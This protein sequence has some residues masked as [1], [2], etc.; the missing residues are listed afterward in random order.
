MGLSQSLY[1]A[2]SGLIN[3]QTR[4]DAIGNNLANINTVG[5]KRSVLQFAD[6]FSQTLRGGSGPSSN[7]GGI[8]PI[9]IGLGMQVASV[10]QDFAQGAMEATGR[11]S[12]LAVEGNGFFKLVNAGETRYSRDGAFTL[13]QSGELQNSFGWY[14]QGWMAN[15]AGT[16]NNGGATTNLVIPLGELKVARATSTVDYTG[17]LNASG[18]VATANADWTTDTNNV[19]R[20]TELF[21]ADGVTPATAANQLQDL[22]SGGVQ[23]FPGAAFSS[24]TISAVKGGRNISATV[25][26]APNTQLSVLMTRI[27]NALGI[28]GDAFS[29]VTFIDG[30]GAAVPP[31]GGVIRVAGNSGTLNEISNITLTP[32]SGPARSLFTQTADSNG[33][34]TVTT[35]AA[36]DSLGDVHMVTLTMALVSQT[37][38]GSTWR[39]YADCTDD[40]TPAL[41]VGSGTVTFDAYGQYLTKSANTINIDLGSQGVTT[42]LV[43][44]PD[45]TLLTQFASATGSEVE[46]RSQDGSPMG[47]LSAYSIDVDGVISGL[48]SNGLRRDLGQVCLTQFANNNG[49]VRDADNLFMI[50][51]NSGLPQDGAPMTASRGGIRSGALES[52]NVDIAKEF[53]DMIMTQ[54]G[55]QA[56]AR[57]ISTSD[58]M[59]VELMNIT[60]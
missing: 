7:I 36:Y 50:G 5:Y 13:G 6:I 46:A 33:E 26:A 19:L 31:V 28:Q 34:S 59:L 14:V 47:V 55:Y 25:A 24:I 52:S 4:L 29:G 20:S 48:F 10:N 58:A 15:S 8:N 39:W 2:I 45:F 12:D 57:T 51:A 16:I 53:T 18:A 32:S 21:L 44:T 17:N 43:V 23:L 38:S 22:Y 9:Q 37:N 27:N 42:P 40:T 56:N 30:S 60:R 3:H 11:T 35:M 1:S 54:R 41:G 49:L